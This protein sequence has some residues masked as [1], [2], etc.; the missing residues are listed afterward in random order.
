[1]LIGTDER[2]RSRSARGSS[3]CATRELPLDLILSQALEG[4]KNKRTFFL[5]HSHISPKSKCGNTVQNSCKAFLSTPKS[6]WQDDFLSFFSS[7]PQNP[8]PQNV[9]ACLEKKWFRTQN[10]SV[11]NDTKSSSILPLIFS[12]S[13]CCF[14]IHLEANKGEKEELSV[15]PMSKFGERERHQWPGPAAA[16]R[17]KLSKGKKWDQFCMGR[18]HWNAPDFNPSELL[19]W[20]K[21]IFISQEP[22]LLFWKKTNPKEAI[23]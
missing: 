21:V 13:L 16:H 10:D 14:L 17:R 20:G 9:P 15:T 18:V 8:T 22:N 19:A 1:M 7:W 6:K 11:A 5:I 4:E 3:H 12:L 2:S 23:S